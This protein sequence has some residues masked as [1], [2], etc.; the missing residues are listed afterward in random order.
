MKYLWVASFHKKES[1]ESHLK[2]K[3]A[4]MVVTSWGHP[5]RLAHSDEVTFAHNPK[6]FQRFKIAL[7]L[8]GGLNHCSTCGKE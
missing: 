1:R 7:I 4:S 6:F 8:V 3:G 5:A 2:E